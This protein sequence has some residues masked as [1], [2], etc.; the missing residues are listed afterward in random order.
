MAALDRAWGILSDWTEAVAD[1]ADERG[2]D[3]YEDYAY[4]CAMSAVAG[5]CEFL[6]TYDD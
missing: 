1:K 6:G 4:S 3:P 5:L 2:K